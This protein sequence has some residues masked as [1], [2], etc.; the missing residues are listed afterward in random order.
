VKRKKRTE[1]QKMEEDY[2]SSIQ[3]AKRWGL[4]Q[5]TI[6]HWRVSGKGPIFN[7]FGGCVKYHI[8]EI[9]RF[10]RATHMAHTSEP[11]NT[12]MQMA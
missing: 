5:S 12:I 1:E 10:E 4:G 3:L 6:R 7:K 11:R 2:L 8:K 9:E